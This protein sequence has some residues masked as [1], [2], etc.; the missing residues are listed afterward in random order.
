MQYSVREFVAYFRRGKIWRHWKMFWGNRV[1]GHIWMLIDI[2][3][4]ISEEVAFYSGW[5]WRLC[6]GIL[7]IA[8]STRCLR[9][10]S[11]R[12]TSAPSPFLAASNN[13]VCTTIEAHFNFIF[14]LIYAKLSNY[15]VQICKKIKSKKGR[16]TFLFWKICCIFWHKKLKFWRFN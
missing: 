11:S 1:L 16:E 2:G 5:L 15:F 6:S 4:V 13:P 7:I 8:A 9:A 10:E 12:V 14:I 3:K